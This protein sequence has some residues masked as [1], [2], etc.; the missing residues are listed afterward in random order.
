MAFALVGLMLVPLF[1]FGTVYTEPIPHPA[2][3]AT[4]ATAALGAVFRSSARNLLRSTLMAAARATSRTVSRRVVRVVLRTLLELVVPSVGRAQLRG[5]RSGLAGMRAV[6]LGF[7]ALMAS[8]LGVVAQAESSIRD[9]LTGG[10]S[11]VVMAGLAALPLLLYVG[12]LDLGTRVTGARVRLVTSFDGLLLQV[13]FTLAGSF[14]PLTTDAEL[15]GTPAQKGRCALVVVMGLIL[16]HY[17]LSLFATLSGIH[18][19]EQLGGLV[20]LY[21]FVFSFPL[22]PLDGGH[23]FSWNRGVWL[24]MWLVVLVTFLGN[25]PG[26]LYDVL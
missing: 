3:A 6:A 9:T 8:F 2:V 10:H 17:L 26:A 19:A 16:V 12:L 20:L 4:G 22:K 14:M 7:V 15:T 13:Y 1:V 5:Q 18:L 25:L 24:A 23:I 11:V 21:G